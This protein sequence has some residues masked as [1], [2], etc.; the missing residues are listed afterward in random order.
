M[1]S[2]FGQTQLPRLRGVSSKAP[3]Y[4]H[5]IVRIT[6]QIAIT[7]RAA[8]STVTTAL[9]VSALHEIGERDARPV[10][11]DPDWLRG[12][13]IDDHRQEVRA[14]V[15]RQLVRRDGEMLHE[16]YLNKIGMSQRQLAGESDIDPGVIN[17]MIAGDSV[18]YGQGKKCAE[19]QYD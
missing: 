8:V 14:F 7:I 12:E 4:V 17:H 5:L 3:L 18:G 11:C 13:Q 2:A 6:R 9:L 10:R 15:G 16:E 19:R 1:A